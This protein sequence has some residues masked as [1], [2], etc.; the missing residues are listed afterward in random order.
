[1]QPDRYPDPDA[2]VYASTLPMSYPCQMTTRDTGKGYPIHSHGAW[3]DKAGN[4]NTDADAGHFHRVREGRVLPDE[5]DGH[6]HQLTMLPCGAGAPQSMA[7]NGLI[8]MPQLGDSAPQSQMDLVRMQA[9]NASLQA[10]ARMRQ[11]IIIGVSAL[12]FVGAVVGAV[13]Y[14]RSE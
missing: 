14:L 11:N 6:T 3:I 7:R 2:V 4:G 12:I 13:M 9:E 5:S 1:M 8:P 10:S